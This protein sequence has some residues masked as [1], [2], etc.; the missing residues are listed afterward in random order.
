MKTDE[1]LRLVWRGFDRQLDES[2]QSVMS[3]VVFRL[4]ERVIKIPDELMPHVQALNR[5][6]PHTMEKA[7]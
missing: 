2:A 7:G 5:L 6:P 4:K 1:L 3:Y